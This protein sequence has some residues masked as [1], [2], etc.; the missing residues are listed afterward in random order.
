MRS[1]GEG[2]QQNVAFYNQC[3]TDFNDEQINA[4]N[5]IAACL[6]DNYEGTEVFNMSAHG[7][8][9]KT[10][11][12]NAILAYARGMGKKCIA[13][14]SSGIAATLLKGGRVALYHTSTYILTYC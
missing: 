10:F 6:A 14:A 4:F 9:G 1:S 11:F 7:G 5:I 8:C 3:I 12:L 2:Q 13:T